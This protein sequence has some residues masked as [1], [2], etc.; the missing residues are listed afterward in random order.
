MCMSKREREDGVH[1]QLVNN[2]SYTT[3]TIIF[4]I[5][6]TTVFKHP[7]LLLP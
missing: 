2:D 5:I 6:A 7:L 3:S 1:M 4:I